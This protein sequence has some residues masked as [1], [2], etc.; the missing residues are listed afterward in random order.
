MDLTSYA[1]LAVRLVN[2]GAASDGRPDELATIEAY[3]VL[4]AD[5][6]Q[7]SVRV[8][9][10]D[11]DALRQLRADLRLIFAAC[12]EGRDEDAAARLNAL[13]AR[14]PIH[15]EI[16]RHDGQSWHL[17]H[18]ESGSVADR[19]AA[20]A[21]LGLTRVLTE[22]GADRLR[23]CEAAACHNVFIDATAGRSRSYCSDR[24]AA[25]ANVTALRYRRRG[26]ENTQ[27]S[28]AAG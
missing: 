1:E 10:G 12:A 16:A 23:T 9:P 3:R 8:L 21:V 20:G 2:T 28:T 22:L 24:C 26:Q 27:A 6:A 13:L 11:L 5:R 17:H 18:A 25:K 4:M 14:H 19:Y 15:P 7:F